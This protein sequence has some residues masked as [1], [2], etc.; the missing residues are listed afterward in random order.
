MMNPFTW[1]ETDHKW[2]E[3]LM[4]DWLK[5]WSISRRWRLWHLVDQ[6]TRLT[7]N[8]RWM[9]E[10]WLWLLVELLL[11]KR[12]DTLAA[13]THWR[14]YRPKFEKGMT[15]GINGFTQYPTQVQGGCRVQERLLPILHSLFLFPFPQ[16]YG[17][18]LLS[19][20]TSSRDVTDA[21]YKLILRMSPPKYF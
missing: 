16:P 14:N 11:N 18:V 2:F 10:V 6:D 1:R 3:G 7:E 9:T 17:W 12:H 21:R 5:R 4:Q 15:R 20:F 13:L 19:C 8:D